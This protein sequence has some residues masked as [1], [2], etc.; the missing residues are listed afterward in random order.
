MTP[1]EFRE[2]ERGRLAVE[3]IA[4]VL[5]RCADGLERLNVPM[6]GHRDYSDRLSDEAIRIA[7]ALDRTFPDPVAVADGAA[8]PGLLPAPDFRPSPPRRRPRPNLNGR[9]IDVRQRPPAFA[10]VVCGFG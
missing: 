7:G 5:E 3:R 4:G 9:P 8:G 10:G 6:D 1:Q 2:L